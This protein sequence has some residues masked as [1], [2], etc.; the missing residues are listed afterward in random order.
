[1]TEKV[2][3]KCGRLFEE[4]R[5]IGV[6]GTALPWHALYPL[7]EFLGDD[8]GHSV[9]AD[10]SPTFTKCA[11]TGSYMREPNI[12]AALLPVNVRAD[13]AASNSVAPQC[14]AKKQGTSE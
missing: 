6:E 12:G 3:L 2:D 1:M 9:E 4:Q 7:G 8:T 10:H 11:A 5:H 13:R 14:P